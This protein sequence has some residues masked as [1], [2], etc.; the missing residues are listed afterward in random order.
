MPFFEEKL[1]QGLVTSRSPAFLRPGEMARMTN[2][3]YVPE[4]VAVRRSPGRLV[5][6]GTQPGGDPAGLLSAQFDNGKGYLVTQSGGQFKVS[7][8]GF[9]GP[10]ASAGASTGTGLLGMAHYNNKFYLANGAERL[11]VLRDNGTLREAG[12]APVVS[13]PNHTGS[14]GTFSLT[15]P[16]FYEYW[17]TEIAEISENG[18][19]TYLESNYEAPPLVV[20]VTSALQAPI[21]RLPG[22]VNANATGR[23]IYRSTVKE[24]FQPFI[25]PVGELIA[26]VGISVDTFTDG[27]GA[28][29]SFYNG[30]ANPES[31]NVT[32]PG[33][34]VADDNAYAVMGINSY[35]SLTTFNIAAPTEP[36]TGIEMTVEGKLNTSGF[37]IFSTVEIQ[38]ENVL[39]AQFPPYYRKLSSKKVVP[40]SKT[41][42]GA[43]TV[44]GSGDLWLPADANSPYFWSPVDFT[45]GAFKVWLY[46]RGLGGAEIDCVKVK[47]YGGGTT[48]SAG[49]GAIGDPFPSVTAVINGEVFA[50]GSNGRPPIASTATVFQGSLVTNDVSNPSIIRWSMPDNPEAFPGFY[51]FDFE[52]PNNDKVTQLLNYNDKLLVGLKGQLWRLDYLPNEDDAV[53]SRGRV[54]TLLDAHNGP[55]NAQSMTT[56]RGPD[57]RPLAAFISRTGLM[58]TDS[59]TTW[60]LIPQIAW[61]NLIEVANF[62]DIQLY[63]NPT[64]WELLVLYRPVGGAGLSRRL[65]VSYHPMHLRADGTLKVSGP[66]VLSNIPVSTEYY[67]KAAATVL[68][69]SGVQRVFTAYSNGD[70]FYDDEA[71]AI[72]HTAKFR[73]ILT[74]KMYLAGLSG[75]WKFISAHPYFEFNATTS[76]MSVQPTVSQT[77]KV[78]RL[79]TTT[80]SVSPTFTGLFRLMFG[81]STMCE[82]LTLNA[83]ES[84]V[85][86]TD[87]LGLVSL[88]IEGTGFGPEHVDG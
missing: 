13:T 5:T 12:L 79:V 68:L 80:K 2:S 81:E 51:F 24:S 42:P 7:A 25:F 15:A 77:G 38:F 75:Q 9:V 22:Q 26:T 74:R 76:G 78:D 32:D 73:D 34:A 70:I 85:T 37:N 47:I 84:A 56:F 55:V 62:A 50:T 6:T 29:G 11:Q 30:G 61:D 72:P 59:Y 40:L 14:A 52:T 46:N 66:T 18:G 1:D 71:T 54:A 82:A 87:K 65:H 88:I 43:V 20:N 86:A 17:V 41:T 48:G 31:S 64:K 57:G 69:S 83:F 28:G 8:D 3:V 53:I 10:Y 16:G 27:I 39:S 49:Q 19:T 58:A 21:I 36:I 67:A 63:N 23:K 60:P 45:N 4:S 35:L 44:G 33:N